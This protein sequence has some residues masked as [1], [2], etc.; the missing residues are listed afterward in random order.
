MSKKV[1]WTIKA[2]T[3]LDQYCAIIEEYSSVNAKKVRREIVLASKGLSKNPY[4]YQID[5]YYPDNPGNI[6]RF[7]KWSYK[8]VYQVKEAKVTILEVYHTSRNPSD[9]GVN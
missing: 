4:L 3:S 8:I 7:F 2:K 5:E 6:R 1:E 9:V